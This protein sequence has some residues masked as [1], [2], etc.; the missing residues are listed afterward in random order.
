M[1][2]F[3]LVY[4]TLPQRY[5]GTAFMVLLVGLK[6]E[7]ILQVGGTEDFRPDRSQSLKVVD[8]MVHTFE[9]LVRC[10]GF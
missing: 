6:D 5:S 10:F 2:R 8:G 3:I 7:Q 9:R 1:T 4:M